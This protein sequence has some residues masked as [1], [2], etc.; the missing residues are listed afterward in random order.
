MPHLKRFTLVA[1]VIV[2]SLEAQEISKKYLSNKTLTYDEAIGFYED[3][4]QKSTKGKLFSY[5]SSDVGKPI[6][7]FVISGDE[8]FDPGSIRKKNKRIILINNS[9]HSGEPDGVDASVKLAEDILVKRTIP[10]PENAVVCI[11]PV[12]NI[13]GFLNRAC[14]RRANQNGPEEIGTRANAK[15]LDL[16]RDFIKCDAGNTKTFSEIFQKWN[17]DVFVDTHVSDGA[18]YTYTMTLISTQYDKLNPVLS[19]FLKNEMDPA[20]YESMKK[21]N[22]EMCPYVELYKKTPNY[23]IIGFFETPRYSTGYA[24]LFNTIG[25]VTETHMLKPFAKRVEATYDFISSV[26]DFTNKNYQK[27]GEVRKQADQ[28]VKEQK[29]F[30]VEWVMDT[31]KWDSFN[32]KGYEAK[33]KPSVISGQPRLYYD[34]KAPYTKPIRNYNTY[35]VKTMIEKP[36]AYV[37][38]QGWRT[39]IERL[40]M[41]NIKMKRFVR[42]TLLSVES[43]YIDDYQ[44]IKNPYEGHYLHS[45]VKVTK[46]TQP[47]QY[48][49]GDYIVEVN[50][51]RNRYIVETLEPQARD[52]YFCWNFF[53][54]ILQHKEGFSN[55][56]FEETAEEIL[57]DHPDI[58]KEFELK[59]QQ[60][61]IFAKNG[62]EQLKFIHQKAPQFIE[63]SFLRYPVARLNKIASLPLE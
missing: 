20:L 60:D 59:K 26:I 61:S 56:V 4:D 22:N 11:I 63:K 24:A 31:T 16:N 12:Y 62:E 10:I 42:D 2:G 43:Y 37:I 36:V 45:N 46:E 8:D 34:E 50:Q 19:N 57:Q 21:K 39:V 53:D 30:P 25:F 3:L 29:E 18:D 48:H 40:Q 49:K 41:N 7:L 5:G 44:T 27:I 14:C 28:F 9:I 38:P 58:K 32:F 33:Y 47:V 6:H 52:S 1:L 55:Y 15:N 35:K 17:P 51:E 54:A 23:G 13:D